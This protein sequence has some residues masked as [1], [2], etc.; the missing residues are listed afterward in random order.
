MRK[1]AN[2]A[3]FKIDSIC[4]IYQK[5]LKASIEATKELF[6]GYKANSLAIAVY[7]SIK[8]EINAVSLFAFTI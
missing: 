2:D 6:A 5:S 7:D 8:D 1:K 4:T 3:K